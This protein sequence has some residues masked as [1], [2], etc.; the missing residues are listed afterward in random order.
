MA[1]ARQRVTIYLS[2]LLGKWL[3]GAKTTGWALNLAGTSLSVVTREYVITHSSSHVREEMEVTIFLLSIIQV[4]WGSGDR[5]Q[6]ARFAQGRA[7]AFWS[8]NW[9]NETLGLAAT[10]LGKLFLSR[11]ILLG[12]GF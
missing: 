8:L 4:S 9:A 1:T 2:F 7:R 11:Q 5:T 12:L 10:F 6:Q 3:M